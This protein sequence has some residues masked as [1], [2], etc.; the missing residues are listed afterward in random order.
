MNLV[1][2]LAYQ[3]NLGSIPIQYSAPRSHGLACTSRQ[4][5]DIEEEGG[6]GMTMAVRFY[7][8]V[9]KKQVTRLGYLVG[10]P[11]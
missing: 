9:E 10:L 8:E 1:D 7:Q 3:Q 6:E 2:E 11:K 4:H 5:V